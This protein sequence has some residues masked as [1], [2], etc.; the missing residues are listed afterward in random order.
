MTVR[1]VALVPPDHLWVRV[2]RPDWT[3]PFD[4]TFARDRGGRWTPPG[5]WPTL[6]LSGDVATARRQVERLLEGTAVTPDDLTDDAF[7][8]VAARLPRRQEVADVVS[9]GGVAAAGLPATY[10][11]D[12]HGGRVTH[13][14]CW[15]VATA[16]HDVGLD[17]VDARSAAS[18][19]GAGRELAWWPRGRAPRP[20]G[21]RVP[22][23]AWRTEAV[24]DARPLFVG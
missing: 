16:A 17:G 23:G 22:Y 1:V 11:D 4:P 20:R 8:L 10:P 14:A 9:D 3:D 13:A 19:S 5:S 2:C 18:V 6:Y 12:G 7:D 24:T 21:G 15:P